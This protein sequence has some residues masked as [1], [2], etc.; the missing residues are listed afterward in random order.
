MRPAS[1]PA[2]PGGLSRALPDVPRWVETRSM[3]LLGD[4]ELFGPEESE[5][6]SFVVR[7]TGYPL[8]SVVGRPSEEAIREAVAGAAGYEVLVPPEN[9]THVAAALPGWEAV[10]ATLHLLGD[11]PRLPRVPAGTVR[12]LE[13]S[14]LDSIEGLPSRLRSEFA[15]AARRSPI[16]ASLAGGR[17]VAF[18]YSVQTESLWDISINTL[19][20]HRGRGYASL[21]IA[22]MIEHLRPL[23]PV[24]GAEETNLP[25]LRLAAKLG[26]IPADE[27][28]VFHPPGA[29]GAGAALR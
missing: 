26:F 5:E 20:G 16:A 15:V 25:S 21:C 2:T 3:L 1:E 13:P 19:E 11:E 7:G 27:V 6:L 12:L 4:C 18:C 29:R 17:P 10:S 24:W 14:E 8:I 23:R 9:E 22:Y 28:L